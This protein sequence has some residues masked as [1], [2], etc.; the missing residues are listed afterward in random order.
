MVWMV[1]KQR[2]A[3]G[4]SLSGRAPAYNAQPL[5]SVPSTVEKRRGIAHCK[6]RRAGNN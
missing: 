6:Q 4:V 1:K 2:S 5:G 3:K